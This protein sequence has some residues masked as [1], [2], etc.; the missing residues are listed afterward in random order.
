MWRILQ[1]EEPGDYILATGESH[2]IREFV[3]EAFAVMGEEIFWKGTGPEGTGILKSTGKTVVAVDPR[4]YR[5]TE[6]DLLLGNPSKAKEKLG[7][8]PKVTF[9][10]LVKIMMKA[11]FEKIR[12]RLE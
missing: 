1:A 3:E 9:K 2:T 7:W 8:I 10:E 6:V 4:Y 11:D 5:P 12:N